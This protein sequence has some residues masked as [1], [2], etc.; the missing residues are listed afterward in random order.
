VSYR[1]NPLIPSSSAQAGD[2]EVLINYLILLDSPVKPGNDEF[3]SFVNIDYFPHFKI[4]YSRFDILFPPLLGEDQGGVSHLAIPR[5]P[6]A[7]P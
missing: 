2:P 1:R 3:Y 4:R 7:S 6:P 5:P